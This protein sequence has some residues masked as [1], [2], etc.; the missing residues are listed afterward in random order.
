MTDRELVARAAEFRSRAYAPYSGFAVGAALLGRSGRIYG[1]VNVENAAYPVGICAE[2]AA[3]AAAVTSGERAF[4]ALAVIAD[5]PEV[6]APC[7]MCRQMLM[8]FP[9]E[10]IILAN[11]AGSLRVLTPEE[12]LPLAFGAAALPHEGDLQ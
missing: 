9:I 3:I 8:E 7:G 4:E 12:L 11:T 6:C 2:R 10:R 1:G 5:S